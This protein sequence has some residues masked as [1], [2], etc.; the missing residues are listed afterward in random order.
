[1]KKRIANLA[2]NPAGSAAY[3]RADGELYVR[4]NDE[5]HVK[6]RAGERAGAWVFLGTAEVL[7][8][9]EEVEVVYDSNQ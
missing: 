1:M 5:L 9:E 8:P 2:A 6:G 4:L 3:I 7:D